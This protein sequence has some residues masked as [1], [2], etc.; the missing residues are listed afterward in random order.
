MLV[1]RWYYLDNNDL[2]MIGRSTYPHGRMSVPHRADPLRTAGRE[3]VAELFARP[4][5]P[6]DL[7]LTRQIIRDTLAPM[8][9]DQR[10]DPRRLQ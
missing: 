10:L 2:L 3:R 4:F 6:C 7:N 9:S 5:V 8:D 1:W